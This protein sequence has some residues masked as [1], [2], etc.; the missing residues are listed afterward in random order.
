MAHNIAEQIKD[1]CLC[2][3]DVTNTHKYMHIHL[4]LQMHMWIQDMPIFIDLHKQTHSTLTKFCTNCTV[5]YMQCT[6]CATCRVLCT[7]LQTHCKGAQVTCAWNSKPSFM[8]GFPGMPLA[9]QRAKRVQRHVA[10]R[11]WSGAAWRVWRGA[12]RRVWR[13]HLCLEVC[14]KRCCSEV[15]EVSP[16]L[17][18]R[19]AACPHGIQ[20]GRPCPSAS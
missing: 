11:V 16:V 3:T 18:T 9:S 6:Q 5:C 7:V 12:A 10:Q 15:L 14:A 4:H 2:S 8:A 17:G 13:R 20:G 19:P 1:T